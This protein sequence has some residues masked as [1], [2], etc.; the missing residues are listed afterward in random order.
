MKNYKK[1]KMYKKMMLL[2]I[3]GAI[4][5]GLTLFDFN[6]V[7]YVSKTVN[8][9]LKS[10]L[11]INKILYGIIAISGIKLLQRDT[12]LPFLGK[13]V[14]PSN[15]VPVKKNK[16]N[17]DRIEILVKPNSKVMYWA[18]KKMNNET[19]HVKKAYDDYSNSGV[20][21]SDAAGKAVLVLEKGSGYIVPGGKYI[22]PHVHY[23]YEITPGMFSRIETI[24]YK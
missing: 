12:M 1:I 3:A 8:Q 11:P 20:T 22:P 4:N 24:K 6:V 19:S 21:I 13:T 16:Y 5:W 17:K 14:I 9:F 23:R 18:A 2:V 10:K 7:E 15:L